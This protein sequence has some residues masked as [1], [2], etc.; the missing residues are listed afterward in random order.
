MTKML[1][2]CHVMRKI[3]SCFLI[4]AFMVSLFDIVDVTDFCLGEKE[5]F[6][7]D[8]VY[9]NHDND[10][11]DYVDISHVPSMP[12]MILPDKI[13]AKPFA[14]KQKENFYSRGETSQFSFEP[15]NECRPPIA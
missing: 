11:M 15:Q 13:T 3:L 6:S 5:I 10:D 2:Y 14:L 12:P 4:F 7:S 8:N 1:Y 9:S